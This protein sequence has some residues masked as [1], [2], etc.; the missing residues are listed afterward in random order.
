MTRNK[1]DLRNAAWMVF[2]FQY[3]EAA[4]NRDHLRAE[5][6]KRLGSEV[7]SQVKHHVDVALGRLPAI[8]QPNSAIMK[9]P[10]FYDLLAAEMAV[11]E[12]ADKIDAHGR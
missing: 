11:Q 4:G 1:S 5:S 8:S 3:D 7:A 6:E 2:G 12:I 9:M 10:E